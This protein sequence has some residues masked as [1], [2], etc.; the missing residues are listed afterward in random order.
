MSQTYLLPCEVFDVWGIDFVGPFPSSRGNKFILVA[1]DYVSKW[2]EAIASSTND[3]RVVVRFVKKLF[4]R[5][6]VPKV[7]ISDRGSHFRNDPLA[8]VLSKYGVQHR[9]GVAYHPQTQGQVENANRDLKAIL[10]KT[11]AQTRKDW[12]EKLDDALWAFRTAYKTPIGTTPFRL[13]Y[14]KS[15]HLPVE[16]EHLALWALRT[17]CLD[18]SSAGKERFFQVNELDEWRAQ[19]FHN[20]YLYKER[21]K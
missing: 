21:V 4:S 18:S 20:S 13:V 15:C 14:G 3:A 19:A 5:F 2:V 12:S 7:L 17:V 1:I 6:R 8:R 16:V 9:Q 11:V 10:E